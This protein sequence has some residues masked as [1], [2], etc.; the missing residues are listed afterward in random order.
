MLSL[1]DAARSSA[2]RD[3]LARMQPL[4]GELRATFL[5]ACEDLDLPQGDEFHKVLEEL[6]VAGQATDLMFLDTYARNGCP[7]EWSL[8]PDHGPTLKS[9]AGRCW[10]T[11][12]GCGRAWD[13]DRLDCPCGQ[14]VRFEIVDADGSEVV[15]VCKGHADDARDALPAGAVLVELDVA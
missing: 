13:Y 15:K 7:A 5:Q 10:C 2:Y 12:V 8:C 6:A 9:S 3:Y 4:T 14:P 1:D 11:A